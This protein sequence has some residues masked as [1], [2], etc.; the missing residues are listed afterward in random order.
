MPEKLVFLTETLSSVNVPLSLEIAK[1]SR[2]VQM[3]LPD[4]DSLFNISML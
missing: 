4:F 3:S 2:S 1:S